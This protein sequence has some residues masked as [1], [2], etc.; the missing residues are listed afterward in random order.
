MFQQEQINH[1]LSEEAPERPFPPDLLGG[2][3]ENVSNTSYW[4]L[5]CAFSVLC[6]HLGEAGR[7]W[8]FHLS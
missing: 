6:V 5:Q 4:L 8:F 1:A 3:L 7:G 2:R